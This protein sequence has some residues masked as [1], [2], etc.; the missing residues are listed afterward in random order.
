[1]RILIVH[2]RY[3][4]LGGEDAV[5]DAESRL[6]QKNGHKIQLWLADNKNL[7]SGTIKK[8]KAAFNCTYSRAGKAQAAQKI[9]AFMPDIVHVHNFFPQISPAVYDACMDANI[10]VVQTL[11]NYRLICPGALLVRG[12]NICEQCITGSPYLSVHHAC[13]RKSY[14]GTLAVARMIATHRKR[15]TWTNK[16]DA[17]IALTRFAKGKFLAGGL[18]EGRMHIK[19]NFVMDPLKTTTQFPPDKRS[20]VLFVGRISHE[21]GV[22][23]LVKAWSALDDKSQLKIVGDGPL[24]LQITAGDGVVLL[25]HQSPQEVSRLM[26]KTQFLVVPSECYEAGL[27][28]VILEA[29][30]HGIPVLA[31][32]LGAMQELVKE[33]MTGM[34]FEA[35]NAKDLS[36]KIAWLLARPGDCLRMGQEARKVYLARYT[37]DKNYSQLMQIYSAVQSHKHLND[38][39]ATE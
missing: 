27:P 7:S 32:R 14:L 5:V 4:Y 15:D 36:E 3:H 23:T 6:L 38:R 20:G 31:S 1:M 25:G 13:Y 33:G 22:E 39:S 24:Q 16:V 28:I 29:F 34:L 12:R 11:H 37:P 8:I 30:S 17:Y 10:P 19:P 18:P 9:A 2:N 35:G 21:K 26:S